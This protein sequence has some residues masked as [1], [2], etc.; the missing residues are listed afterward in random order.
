MVDAI[1]DLCVT[2]E[3]SILNAMEAIDVTAMKYLL[4]IDECGRLIGTL[5]DGD[6]R[7]SVL[8]GASY[9]DD[10]HAV[11]H[12]EFLFLNDDTYSDEDAKVLLLENALSYLPVLDS[13][14]KVI[15]IVTREKLLDSLSQGVGKLHSPIFIMAGGRGLRMEPFTSVLPKPLIPVGNKPIIQHVIEGFSRYGANEFLISVGYKSRILKAYFEDMKSD[16]EFRF[17]DEDNPLG[18]AGSIAYLKDQIT[19]PFF[20][21]NCD[22][23]LDTDYRD[24]Y[25]FHVDKKF[26]LSLIASNKKYTIPYGTCDV[27]DEG[28][29]ISIEEKPQ[30]NAL[31]STG[32]YLVNPDV[33]EFMTKG[34]RVDMNELIADVKSRGL[35][36]GVFPVKEESW[37]DVG[38]WSEYRATLNKLG[39]L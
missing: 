8:K 25:E 26:S 37:L 12:K 18:T 4:V 28:D 14:E 7:R 9:E 10:I 24:F 1:D 15:R 30:L 2:P 19:E 29:L 13:D 21:T 35:S 23:I 33:L 39:D 20:V 3:V 22:I 34:V 36:V 31:V 11:Y 32:V 5:S 38:E 27:N 16:F 17:I 6:I